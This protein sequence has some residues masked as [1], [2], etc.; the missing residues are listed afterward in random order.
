[1]SRHKGLNRPGFNHKESPREAPKWISF[2]TYRELLKALPEY[3]K[4]SCEDEI[5][6]FRQR[7]GS[8]GEWY[9]I[10][11]MDGK[12]CKIIKEGWQ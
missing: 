8:W 9:S 5:H 2:P 10:H 1:M 3:F 6:V 7:R 12:K 4:T 11:V